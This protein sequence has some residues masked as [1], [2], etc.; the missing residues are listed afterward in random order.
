MRLLTGIF[1]QILIPVFTFLILAGLFMGCGAPKQHQNRNFPMS[2]RT[3]QKSPKRQESNQQNSV[4][5]VKNSAQ[6]TKKVPVLKQAP[7]DEDEEEDFGC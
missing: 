3:V 5:E 7:S 2:E 1:K 6:K 4:S